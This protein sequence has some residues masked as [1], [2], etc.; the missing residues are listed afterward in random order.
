MELS[1]LGFAEFNPPL[2]VFDRLDAEAMMG[3]PFP[4]GR[5]R[6][7]SR[8]ACWGTAHVE[9]LLEAPVL[10]SG[11]GLQATR[12]N[13]GFHGRLQ[14]ATADCTAAAAMALS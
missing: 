12:W 11:A 1:R 7:P 13:T 3:K 9:L 10:H 6:L 4:E 14:T 5:Y 2:E 8:S